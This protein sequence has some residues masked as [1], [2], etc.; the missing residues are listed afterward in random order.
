M[1]RISAA[2]AASLVSFTSYGDG[3]GSPEG[4]LWTRTTFGALLTPGSPP[5]TGS[6]A[7]SG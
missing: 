6:A 3:D 1:L 2:W 7:C 4:W 5:A